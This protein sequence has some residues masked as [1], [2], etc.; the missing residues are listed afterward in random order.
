MRVSPRRLATLL[1][2]ASAAVAACG[3]DDRS[4]EAVASTTAVASSPPAGVAATTEAPAAEY[5]IRIA[6]A[7]GE[8]VIESKPVRVATVA[9]ANH[10]VAL[11]LG[12]VPV[13][14]N[15]ARWGDDDGDGVLPWV[16]DRLAELGAD[17][18]V[19][20][21]ETDGIDLEAVAATRPDVILAAYSGITR[22][23]YDALSKIAP[24]VAYPDVAWGASFQ[25]MVL[26]NSAGL[27]LAA[28]GERF[29][30]D[31]EAEMAE[32]FAAYPQLV[33]KSVWFGYID[34]ADLSQI[35][36]YTTHDSRPAFT[37]DLGMG[38]PALIAER[39]AV[40][41]G[42]FTISA[43]R[44]DELD[45]V[46]IFVTVGDATTLAA[47]QADPVLATIPAIAD[48]RVVILEDSTPLAASANPTPLSIGWGLA[49]YLDLFAAAVDGT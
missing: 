10:E 18:P 36:Y 17:V 23:E 43:E 3:A 5:P 37:N 11:A 27:G 35:G 26:L 24:T 21:D 29:V 34:P 13:G 19:L 40:E 32:T 45:D 4:D 38:T 30:A 9:W 15:K 42:Y 44:A 39:S 46:D 28:E 7:H 31:L 14:M 8:T 16:E 25:E 6:H 12:I 48:G 20:F 49:D 41:N 22:E 47:L 33:G 2:A 1:V